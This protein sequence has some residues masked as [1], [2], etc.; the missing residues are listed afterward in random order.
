M[1]E[2]VVNWHTLTRG[3]KIPDQPYTAL[4][5]DAPKKDMKGKTRLSYTLKSGTRIDMDSAQSIAWVIQYWTPNM[6]NIDRVPI[7]ISDG[8]DPPPPPHEPFPDRILS[9]PVK[10]V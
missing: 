8:P 9:G 10:P 1:A 4:T 3:R 7:D 6:G 5:G 2:T